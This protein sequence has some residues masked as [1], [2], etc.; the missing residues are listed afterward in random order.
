MFDITN[1]QAALGTVR[2]H[3]AKEHWTD[4][5]VPYATN[6]IHPRAPIG[7]IVATPTD[8]QGTQGPIPGAHLPGQVRLGR[9]GIPLAKARWN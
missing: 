5:P 3:Q 7:G 9:C 2:V 1:G 6:S 8:D 4:L